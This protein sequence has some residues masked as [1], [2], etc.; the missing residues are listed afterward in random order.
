MGVLDEVELTLVNSVEEAYEFMSWLGERREVLAIDTET[1]GLEFWTQPLR[2]VQFGDARRGWAIPWNLWGGVVLEAI[3]KYDRPTVM[4]NAKF[5]VHFLERHGGIEVPWRQLHDT[6]IMAHLLDSTQPTGLKPLTS[7]L[8]DSR[9]AA[10]SQ[11]LDQAMAEQKWTWGTVPIDFEPYW[12][13]GALDAVLTARLHEILY[14]QILGGY[15]EVYD[16]EMQVERICLGMER[17]GARFDPLFTEDKLVVLQ[18]YVEE[19]AEWVRQTYGCEAGS[20]QKI[21]Q[22]LQSAGVEF[23]KLTKNGA[24][25]LDAEVLET[26]DHPLAQAILTR[27]RAQKI[28]SG[29]LENFLDFS[30]GGFLHPGINTLGARTGRMSIDRP[31]LQTLPRADEGNP[32]AILVRDCFIP[33][34]G[35]KLVMV[36]FDQI[37]MRLLCHFA[38]DAN[39]RDSILAGDLHTETAKKVYGDPN[40]GK[41]DQRRQLAKNAGFAKVYGAGLEK[42]AMTA[43]TDVETAKAFLDGYDAQYPGVRIFQ[44]LVQNQGMSRKQSDGVAWVRS[45]V[46]RVHRAD[47]GKEYTLVNYLIQGTAGDVLKQKMVDLDNAGFGDYMI[48]PVHDEIVFDVPKEA[49]DEGVVDEIVRTMEDRDNW[50]VPLT[51]GADI[52]ERWGD[53]YR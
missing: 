19:T 32:F 18:R 25:S 2:L 51:V 20:N 48:L 38:N 15:T 22:V 26:I 10:M 5:D 31:A 9:A 12:A 8:V 24:L 4:H 6:R 41:K 11:V 47:D 44:N 50:N 23:T 29:Y 13:Y 39:M 53:K 34:D 17:R 21:I 28:V 14:P 3:R 33:R 45:P 30:D 27:R 16:L 35:N 46:G 1:G 36:D 43:K 42:F 40:I 49:I 37:E 7:R 52:V